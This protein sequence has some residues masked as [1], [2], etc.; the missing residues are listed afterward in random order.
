MEQLDAGHSETEEGLTGSSG[1][2]ATVSVTPVSQRFH[3]FYNMALL[4]VGS[5]VLTPCRQCCLMGTARIEGPGMSGEARERQDHT[6][7][8]MKH[9]HFPK[10]GK[11]HS[12]DGILET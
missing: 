7:P 1:N 9:K 4:S 3:I 5:W 11:G 8:F 2:W 6:Q 12:W 10:Q